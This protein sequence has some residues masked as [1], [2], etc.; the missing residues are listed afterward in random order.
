MDIHLKIKLKLLLESKEE[1]LLSE[2]YQLVSW[3]ITSR[4]VADNVI[5]LLCDPEHVTGFQ[6]PPS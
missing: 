6:F 4:C 2:K 5:N 1:K 3:G